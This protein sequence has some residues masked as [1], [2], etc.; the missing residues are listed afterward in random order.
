LDLGSSL[1]LAFANTVDEFQ[2]GASQAL[3]ERVNLQTLFE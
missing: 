2:Q 3:I 1:T